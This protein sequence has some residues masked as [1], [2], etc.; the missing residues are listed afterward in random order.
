MAGWFLVS[1]LPTYRPPLAV[2]GG[3]GGC[4]SE[5]PTGV[6]GVG[7]NAN[8][9]V[10]WVAPVC[11]GGQSITDYAVQYSADSGASWATYGHSA[12][13]SLSINVNSLTN[14]TA[15][16]FQV[17]AITSSG[18]GAWSAASASV[19][20]TAAIF[21]AIPD[22]TTNTA[23]S[24]EASGVTNNELGPSVWK[25]FNYAETGA[26]QGLYLSRAPSNSPFRMVQYAFP[27]GQTSLISGYTVG[28]SGYGSVD[29][30]PRDWRFYGSDDLSSWTLIEARTD[31]GTDMSQWFGAPTPAGAIKPFTLSAVVN[32]RA[33]RWE[34]WS[35][36]MSYVHNVN[37]LP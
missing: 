20:P 9:D 18:T 16:V 24:G 23:P 26:A 21:R 33:Y 34:F 28:G 11:T 19:T 3:G 12:S 8:A 37:L 30:L 22:M 31:T 35:E 4:V 27:D 10:S 6:A 25:A 2:A 13:T 36:L 29:A 32:Y 14:G 5:A 17:A 7:R 1:P 15:Y